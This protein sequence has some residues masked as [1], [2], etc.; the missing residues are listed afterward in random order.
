MS[1]YQ[2]ST[3]SHKNRAS[4]MVLLE[5]TQKHKFYLI[6]WRTGCVEIFTEGQGSL[7]PPETQRRGQQ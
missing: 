1:H 7:L 2:E 4:V 6:P 3:P 5:L